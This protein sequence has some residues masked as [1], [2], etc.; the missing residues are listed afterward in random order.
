MMA[1]ILIPVFLASL[2]SLSLPAQVRA[3]ETDV[4]RPI[5]KLAGENH[6]YS[7]DFLFFKRLAE[8][9][10]RFTA[11]GQPNIFKAELIG[12]T[13]GIASWLAGDRTQAYTSLMA[14]T[15]DG[16]LRSIEYQSR[17]D[18]HRWGKWQNRAK[19]HRYDYDQGKVFE[20]KTNDGVLLWAKEHAIPEGMQP[21]DM[22]TAF[23]NLR[24]GVYGPLLRGARF[25]IPTYSG[26]DFFDIEVDVL[27]VE[28]QAR[29]SDFPAHGLLVM[30]RIDREIFESDSGNLYFW[31][32]DEGIPER[33]IVADV[34]GLGDVRGYITKEGL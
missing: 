29:Q 3:Q 5:F 20:E 11:T 6:Q 17:I 25:Q 19:R 2:L 7:I 13:L 22:L 10:L 26:G 21:V 12:R 1:R 18:K 28:Q 23:Y 33:G 16:S 14:L 15:P 34:I 8:G 32:N 24:T 30:A 9:E 27:T 31:L 4:A